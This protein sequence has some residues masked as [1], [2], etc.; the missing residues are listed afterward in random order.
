MATGSYMTPIYSRSQ[1]EVQGDLHILNEFFC[2]FHIYRKLQSKPIEFD[3][4]ADDND[5]T[6][7]DHNKRLAEYQ[8]FQQMAEPLKTTATKRKENK[9]GF[10]SPTSRQISKNRRT[11]SQAELNFKID[12][13]NLTTLESTRYSRIF[14]DKY[15]AQ[16]RDTTT[17]PSNTTN[18]KT[19]NQNTKNNTTGNNNYLQPPV[20]LKITDDY[21]TQ[22]KA[23][24]DRL[25]SLR[26]RM[27]GEYFKLYT[28][29]DDQ[30]HK[31]NQVLEEFQY[32]FYSITPKKR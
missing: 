29:T 13:Q 21:R 19:L 14:F 18:R 17:R 9:D 1:S 23:L 16:A 22:M 2:N 25:S 7:L 15:S 10:T 8:K 26:S 30:H 24:N 31:L 12:L 4:V 28:D 5:P 32:E 6:L 11:I 20:F 3:G 27:T